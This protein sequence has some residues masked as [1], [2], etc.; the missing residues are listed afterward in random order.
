MESNTYLEDLAVQTLSKKK[1]FQKL[2]RIKHLE[3][4]RKKLIAPDPEVA[5]LVNGQTG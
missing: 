4:R 3:K 2:L 5:H 1:P